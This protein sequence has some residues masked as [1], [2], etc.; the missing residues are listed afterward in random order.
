MDGGHVAEAGTRDVS[1]DAGVD[2]SRPDAGHDTGTADS[3]THDTGPGCVNPCV[4]GSTECILQ[5]TGVYG[6]ST[7]TVGANGCT[8]RGVPVSCGANSTC[9]SDGGIAACGCEPGFA[10]SSGK[11]IPL[12]LTAPRPIAPLSTATVTSQ[13]PL[14]HWELP[15]G[16]DGAQVDICRD[17]ACTRMVTSFLVSGTRGSPAAAL[18]AGVYFWRLRG[19][20]GSVVGTATGPVWEMVVG[21]ASAPVNSSWGTFLDVNG[22]GL[23]D[24]A[25][26]MPSASNPIGVV[27]LFLGTPGGPSTTPVAIPGPMMAGDPF[28]FFGTS[29]AS[30]GDVNGDGYSDL[31]VS[32]PSSSSFPGA[33]FLYPGGPEGLTATPTV[34]EGPDPRPGF[35]WVVASAGDV[36]GDGYADVVV[37][38]ELSTASA[39]LFL[40]SANGLGATPVSLGIAGG[41][42]SIASAGD[43]NGDGYGDLVVGEYWHTTDDDGSAYVILGSSTGPGSPIALVALAGS[44][45]A[46]GGSV[47]GAGDVNGD[48][49]ADF[50]VGAPGEVPGA[51]VYLGSAG[52]FDATP[53]LLASPQGGTGTLSYPYPAQFAA[54]VAGAGD[55]N[56]DGFGDILIGAPT[57]T[58]FVYVYLGSPGG[59]STGAITIGGGGGVGNTVSGAGDL[60]GDGFA[61]MLV[62]AGTVEVFWG[63]PM[64]PTEM[65]PTPLV[66]HGPAYVTCLAGNA[67]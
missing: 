18:A 57:P 37:S 27:N 39:V 56:G 53:T 26:G 59:I 44:Y 5:V 50:I 6:V 30:A 23:P 28:P 62:G 65:S 51:Y 35:G 17:R 9:G 36:N 2:A 67:Q 19:A 45:G 47:G 34:I 10:M 7:C 32:A 40:G 3:A 12:V 14:L 41:T 52:G 42:D 13:T 20:V 15:S 66:L 25:A 63:G 43:L 33:V 48:G 38:S 54:S 64:S 8:R 16:E 22:D 55:V 24:I 61:D 29:V 11:C 1:V 60:N 58:G 49:Y 46:F 4:A 31:V 21:H